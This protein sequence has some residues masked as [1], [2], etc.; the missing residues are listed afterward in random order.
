M[1]AIDAVIC[2]IGDEA[3]ETFEH[4]AWFSCLMDAVFWE[5]RAKANEKFEYHAY[6]TM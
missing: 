4:I 1:A 2:E 5:V 3:E 6:D